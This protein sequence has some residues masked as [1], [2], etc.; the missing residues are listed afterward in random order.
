[1]Y[2]LLLERN[3]VINQFKAI[4]SRLF[5]TLKKIDALDVHLRCVPRRLI[6]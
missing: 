1:M 5:I 2:N 6:W 4:K 3:I